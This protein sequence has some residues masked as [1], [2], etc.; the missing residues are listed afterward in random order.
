MLKRLFCIMLV[1]I[2]VC[3]LCACRSQSP[4][5]TTE[6]KVRNAVSNQLHVAFLGMSIGGNEAK[7]SRG[8]VT[9]IKQISD[10][11]YQVSGKITVIDV[12]GNSWN[13]D[14]DCIV[15]QNTSG[16]WNAGSLKYVNSSWR[17]G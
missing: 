8:T 16:D 12:Y 13:N 3:G 15:T 5:E 6:D 9:N 14:Y 17:K 10:T 2:S 4:A 1:L 7:S 11:E